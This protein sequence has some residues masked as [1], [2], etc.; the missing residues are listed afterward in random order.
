LVAL[1]NL[2]DAMVAIGGRENQLSLEVGRVRAALSDRED[3][4]AAGCAAWGIL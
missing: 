1:M 4:S 3:V 2:S